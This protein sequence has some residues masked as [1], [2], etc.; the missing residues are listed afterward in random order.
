MTRDLSPFRLD[1]QLHQGKKRRVP[2]KERMELIHEHFPS[3][4]NAEW[5]KGLDE[6]DIGRIIRDILKFDQVEPGRSGPRPGLEYDKG[7]QSWRDL[8]GQEY[9]EL[10]FHKAFAVLARENSLTVVS[11]KTNISRSRVH[12]L[13]RNEEAPTVN[14]LRQVAE[15]Y[16]RRPAYFLEYRC[17]YIVAAISLRLSK[18]PELASVLYRKLVNL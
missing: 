2:W 16:G 14:D 11:R 12:R 5:A 4:T 10:P 8:T 1:N 15:A 13:L 9:S 18:E 7:M 6:T 3:T 17:E